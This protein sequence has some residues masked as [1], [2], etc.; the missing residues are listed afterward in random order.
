MLLTS[1]RKFC[2]RYGT[3]TELKFGLRDPSD[4]KA[5]FHWINLA[6]GLAVAPL[7]STVCQSDQVLSGVLI[8]PVRVTISIWPPS[9]DFHESLPHVEM[10]SVSFTIDS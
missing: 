6:F 1:G 3:L 2:C 7:E 9:R 8:F 10:E 4:F 5:A